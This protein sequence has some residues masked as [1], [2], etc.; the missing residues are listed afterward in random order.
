MVSPLHLRRSSLEFL[1]FIGVEY[2]DFDIWAY[3]MLHSLNTVSG[4]LSR[5][6]VTEPYISVDIF[7]HHCDK[8]TRTTF[9]AFTEVDETIGSDVVSE[10]S[11]LDMLRLSMRS[12]R[13]RVCD[14]PNDSPLHPD[15][16]MRYATAWA[17]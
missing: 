8:L 14:G 1:C 10:L 11:S 15:I 4:V 9:V 16:S 6:R 2:S 13:L 12:F 5:R 3:E 7:K 17:I